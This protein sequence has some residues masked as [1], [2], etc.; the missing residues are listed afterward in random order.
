M[1]YPEENIIGANSTFEGVLHLEGRL[2][3]E[4]RY[5]SAK[6]QVEHLVVGKKGRMRSDIQA[7]TVVVEGIVIGSIKAQVRVI[8]MP[9]ARVVG[10]ITTPE[11]V[12]QTGVVYE[13]R[14]RIVKED[15]EKIR[16]TIEALYQAD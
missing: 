5:E 10:D 2:R 8:L 11:L 12:V 4:G 6:L 16:E 1:G 13:G 15:E 7:Q 9:T 14:T 3:I